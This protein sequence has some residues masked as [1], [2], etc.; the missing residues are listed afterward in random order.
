MDIL[1]PTSS[2]EVGFF[3]TPNFAYDVAVSGET[4]YVAVS[5][6]GLQVV[7]VSEP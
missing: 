4:L 1:D 7:D 5:D 6:S 3:F 2:F